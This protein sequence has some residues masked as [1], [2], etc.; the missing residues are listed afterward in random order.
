MK[1]PAS[2]LWLLCWKM[3]RGDVP[4]DCTHAVLVRAPTAREARERASKR[5]A[6]EGSAVWL[7]PKR[8]SCTVLK[9]E[10]PSRVIYVAYQ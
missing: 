2:R 10:G 7:D 3:E 6:D 9:A 8:S 1:R 5:A 4:I